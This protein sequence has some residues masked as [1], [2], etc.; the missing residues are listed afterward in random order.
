MDILGAIAIGTEPYK[1]DSHSTSLSQRISRKD[2]VVKLEMLRQ[3]VCQSVYQIIVMMILMYL[4][5]IM[6]FDKPFNLVLEPL[7][8]EKT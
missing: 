4:G 2:N 5:G 6:F 1:K 3:I 8:D 7:R